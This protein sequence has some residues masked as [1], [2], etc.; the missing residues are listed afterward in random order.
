[1]T[2]KKL[3]SKRVFA[4][5]RTQLYQMR[6]LFILFGIVLLLAPTLT[7]WGMLAGENWMDYELRYVKNTV[8]SAIF[9]CGFAPMFGL[10]MGMAVQQFG[11][12]HKRQKL[13][14]FHATPVLRSEH[15]LGRV[16][17]A[18]IALVSASLVVI[19]GQLFAVSVSVGFAGN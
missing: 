10:G 7:S 17:A 11:Y 15:Y 3:S 19:L 18:F 6:L 4:V 8:M 14:Y 5:C 13:D 1:M 2:L 12:L 9:I 16:I